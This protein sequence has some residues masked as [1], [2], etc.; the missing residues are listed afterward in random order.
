MVYA[1]DGM[2]IAEKPAQQHRSVVAEKFARY[3]RA[4]SAADLERLL[5]LD[6]GTL[7]AG[8]LGI[9]GEDIDLR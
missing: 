3:V 9:G 6:T 7:D 8:T 2:D 5:G 4:H 1:V